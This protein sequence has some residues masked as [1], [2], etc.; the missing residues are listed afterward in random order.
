MR[1]DRAEQARVLDPY[2]EVQL[3]FA[4]R[5]AELT[6]ERLGETAYRYTNLSRRLG[7]GTPL[8]EPPTTAWLA[9]CAELETRSDLVDQ[10]ALTRRTFLEQP[11]E[12]IPLPGQRLFGCFAHEVPDEQG[13]VKIHFYN[14]DTDASGGPLAAHKAGRRRDELAAMVAHI[15]AAHPGATAIRGGSWLYNLD[16]YRRLFPADYVASRTPADSVRLT[17]TSTWGQLID[18]SGAIR[19]AMRDTLMSNLA[20]LDPRQPWL[21]FPL[22]ALRTVAPLSSFRDHFGV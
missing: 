1:R 7:Q 22:R 16:A 15:Q 20:T 5:M 21:A 17:G 18:S 9:Y 11:E 14:R 8:L 13:L 3:R 10:V 12:T 4:G 6:G 19:P 2:F